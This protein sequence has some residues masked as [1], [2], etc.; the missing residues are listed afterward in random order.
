[1][2]AESAVEE[3]DPPLKKLKRFS[4]CF[5]GKEILTVDELFDQLKPFYF[6]EYKMLENNSQVLPGSNTLS[7]DNLHDYLQYSVSSHYCTTL[8]GEH[9]ASSAITQ[10]NIRE[11]RIMHCQTLPRW[12]VAD[13]RQWMI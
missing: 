2:E 1:M 8:Y 6:L 13:Q 11:T 5:M 7:A 4:Q 10:H 9:R 12:R 3:S